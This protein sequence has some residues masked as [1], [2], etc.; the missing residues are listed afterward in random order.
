LRLKGV[1]PE[2]SLGMSTSRAES[3]GMLS[4][5]EVA[6]KAT[7]LLDTT[8]AGKIHVDGP[9]AHLI[10]ARFEIQALSDEASR[11][12]FEKGI[13]EVPR[14][15]MGK[16]IPCFG[17]ERE[18]G[19]LE[20]LWTEACDEPAARVMLLTAPA[21][22]GKSR[23]RHEFCERIQRQGRAFEF[24]VGRGDP[25][26]DAA[27]FA[28]LGPALLTAAGIA[29]GEPEAVQRKRLTAHVSRFLPEMDSLR[30]AAFLGEMANLPFPDDDLLPLRAAR[31]DA[32]LMAD[33]KLM[34]WLEWLEAEC[35]QH[36]VLLVLED[37]HWG[38][39]PSVSFVDAALRVLAEKP[40]MV[41]AL[42]RPEVDRRFPGIWN[43]RNPQQINLVPLSPRWSQRLVEHVASE[44]PEKSARWIVERA[45]GNPFYLQELLRAAVDGDRVG[46]D[47]KLPDTVLGMV[48]A[49]F[50]GFGPEAKLVLRA[51]SIFGQVFRPAGVK[52]LLDGNVR[53]DVDRWLDILE[54]QEILFSRSTSDLREYAFRHALL[55]Q[56]AY[57]MLPPAEKR[58]GHLVAGQYLDQAGER[59]GIVLADHF[60]RAG[61]T[62]RATHWLCAAAQQALDANDIVEALAR[63]ERG[64]I[65]GAAGEKLCVLRLIEA[66]ARYWKG[67]Y[68]EA[69]GASREAL[70]S[71]DERTRLSALTALFDALG[72][73]AKYGEILT[74]YRD[75]V[76]PK[77]SELLNVW[78]ECVVV[79]TSY[80]SMG[81]DYN[82]VKQTLALLDK[83][84]AHLEPILVGRTEFLKA[85]AERAGGNQSQ[86]L[87]HFKLAADQFESIGLHLDAC[88]ALATM[89]VTLG[90]VGQL[91]EAQACLR[92]VLATTRRLDLK[93]ILGG[94][95]QALANILAYQGSL[96]DAR[97]FGEQALT[98]TRAQSDRRFQGCAEAYLS[99]TEYLAK[100]Y[101]R[102]ENF[103]RA[104]LLT[105]E[106][107]IS[108][109][110]FAL[111]LLARALLPQGRLAEALPFARDAF[112]QLES[113]G[114]VDDGE[115]TI[116]LALAECLIAAGDQPAAQEAVATTAKWLHTRAETIDDPSM[117]ES[118][119]TRIPEHRCIL[120]LAREYGLPTS[121]ISPHPSRS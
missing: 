119:L 81:G 102:A 10:E 95:L 112:A 92:R 68:I 100:D 99:V 19:L 8:P 29:G 50:D 70:V 78:L 116:R 114:I 69:E 11:L 34:V 90:E 111:A 46:D 48:Q 3:G 85:R 18:I 113:L 59:E 32:R 110:P 65:L 64:A 77:E 38:D 42:A 104:A 5:Q 45:Q 73:Q 118:F 63:V 66:R 43:E 86:A 24:L 105:W 80:L 67:E 41:L 52:A 57:E 83:S 17:R 91:E 4:V 22:G 15:L 79:A 2:S 106:A 60:E 30:T 82:L 23:V 115:A 27:P 31:K 6:G 12:L 14:T 101:L 44:I 36:P 96:E 94:V 98:V 107:V 89:S 53:K 37:L 26:R 25:M 87:V 75:L 61:D 74:L 54:K 1:F 51:G 9:T 40:F 56:A 62:A 108:S 7:R 88:V 13:R 39:A 71:G 72:P 33:Q 58:L 35:N 55:R 84:R 103:A 49:R 21:G 47:S 76:R 117:R 109:R 93:H 120:E 16:E 121:G 20:T 97:A 28:L